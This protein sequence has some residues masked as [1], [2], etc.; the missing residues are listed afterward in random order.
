MPG[1]HILI[2]DDEIGIRELLSEI[3]Q[4]EGYDIKLAEN[5]EQAR[6]WRNQTRPD[7]VLLDIW[8]PDCDGVSLLKEWANNGQL[9]M[10]VVMMSGHGTIETAVEA[11]RIGAIDYLEKP[12]GLQ[13]LLST[14]SRAIKTGVGHGGSD[15][16]L[17]NLGKGNAIQELKRQLDLVQ[18]LKTPILLL[19]EPG[20]GFESC[21]RFL[22]HANTPFVAPE[23]IERALDAPAD[24]LQQTTNGVLFLREIGRLGTRAQQGLLQVV[25][26]LDKFNIRLV[27]ATCRPL[28]ELTQDRNFDAG[29]FATISV[30]QIPVPP[31]K[32]HREDVPELAHQILDR[33]VEEKKVPP[34]RFSVAALNALRNH[35]WPGNLEQLR[36]LV[37]TL[38][39]TSTSDEI[40]V[41]EVN[42]LLAPY[43][44]QQTLGCGE[45]LD[46][47]LRE[48][49]DIFERHYFEHHIK[50]E[51]GN[52]SRVA[53]KV[54]LERTHLYRKL[55]QLGIRFSKRTT[56]ES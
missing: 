10:P 33:L 48:A 30:L 13:K 8:M 36:N 20:V 17:A 56:E 6:Q 55:K 52:M 37:A 11:T 50:L 46:L 47:P 43:A 39:M 21:A 35:D 41:N 15:L 4:D 42:R 45:A 5:A 53:E 2:V 44:M 23:Q 24:L 16:S 14:V 40:G 49:R 54:G 51:N 29:L 22:Q 38:A 32:A 19:G 25:A 12:I 18:P 27:C 28:V 3:L 31:L 34:R 9:T 7:L 1:K 26:K